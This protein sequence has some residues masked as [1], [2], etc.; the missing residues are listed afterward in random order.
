MESLIKK[1]LI[2]PIWHL[3]NHDNALLEGL[4]LS[5]HMPDFSFASYEVW[6]DW[7]PMYR[8]QLAKEQA[9]YLSTMFLGKKVG[10]FKCSSSYLKLSSP[11]RAAERSQYPLI[12]EIPFG[13]LQSPL[14]L[15]FDANGQLKKSQI[16]LAGHLSLGRPIDG[17][18]A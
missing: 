18:S 6:G 15:Y 12:M 4:S 11:M 2:E 7:A 5:L 10:R 16:I 8:V 9:I 14:K 3:G 17:E 1:V 13:E